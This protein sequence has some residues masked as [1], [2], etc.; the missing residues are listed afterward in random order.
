M[1]AAEDAQ[2]V[3]DEIVDERGDQLFSAVKPASVPGHCSF[4]V[5]VGENALEFTADEVAALVA[6]VVERAR[7]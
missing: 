1:V 3:G 2:R 6:E 7:P 5:S 4:E